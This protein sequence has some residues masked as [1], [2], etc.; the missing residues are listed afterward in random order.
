[1][2]LALGRVSNLPTVATNTLAGAALGGALPGEPRTAVAGLALCLT[3]VGGMFLNDAFDREIDRRERPERP[4]PSGRIS[5][6]EVFAVGFGLLA[7]GV[8][9]VAAVER[10]LGPATFAAAVLA[11]LVVLYDARHKQVA[12][13]PWVMGACRGASLFVAALAA[14][15][16]APP[17]LFLAAVTLA[18]YVV[19]LTYVARG[20]NGSRPRAGA[21]LLLLASPGWLLFGG[22][23]PAP[24]WGVAALL[25]GHVGFVVRPL[26][27][28]GPADVG[29]AVGGLIAGISLVDALVLA[30]LDEPGLAV[31]AI[32]AVPATRALQR[33]VRGT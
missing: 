12:A 1:M 18:A 11:A 30:R 8:L 22:S 31:L 19:G 10:R 27:R 2:Y 23:V 4:I 15:G 28:A 17:G 7:A 20:E 25:A 6:S 13:A 3:Y 24:A 9:L 14:G 32:L 21:G 26:F 16:R 5:A 29:R 33:R